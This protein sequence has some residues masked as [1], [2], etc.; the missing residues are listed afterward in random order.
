MSGNRPRVLVVEDEEDLRANV[1]YRFRREG[2]EVVEAGSGREALAAAISRTP[3]LVLLDIS[4]P[5][6]DGNEVLRHLRAWRRGSEMAVVMLTAARDPESV[7][8]AVTGGADEYLAKPFAWVDLLDR[9]RRFLT[10]AVPENGIRLRW[11][12]DAVLPEGGRWRI[13]PFERIEPPQV[14][15]IDALVRFL[16][17]RCPAPCVLDLTETSV[18]LAGGKALLHAVRRDL[19]PLQVGNLR[20]A[21]AGEEGTAL[22]R[23]LAHS[24]TEATPLE[25]VF[26][27]TTPHLGTV[28]LRGDIDETEGAANLRAAF[29][30]ASEKRETVLVVLD[31]VFLE[32]WQIEFFVRSA[33]RFVQNQKAIHFVCAKPEPR[34]L[35]AERLKTLGKVYRSVPEALRVHG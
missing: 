3:H 31:E 16:T 1:R 11:E 34:A 29:D 28:T 18:P 19:L 8:S 30:A 23:P 13:G 35:L 10:R 15:E 27:R 5:D 7:R 21:R 9:T 22:L 33:S 2:Y 26:D 24:P 32:E 20:K 17:E 6:I 14:G 12:A 4:L 25:I